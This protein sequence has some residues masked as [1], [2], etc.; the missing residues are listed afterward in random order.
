MLEFDFSKLK[1]DH[2]Y[3]TGITN[4]YVHVTRDI[5][6]RKYWPES[7]SSGTFLGKTT[8]RVPISY[9]VFQ[10]FCE[11]YRSNKFANTIHG[12]IHY[13]NDEVISI[14]IKPRMSLF[15]ESEEWESPFESALGKLKEK[16]ADLKAFDSTIYFD[17]RYLFWDN[18]HTQ[19]LN[20]GVDSAIT[21]KFVNCINMSSLG[22]MSFKRNFNTN[23]NLINTTINEK[24]GVVIRYQPQSN[25][26][27]LTLYS[28]VL[29]IVD[30]SNKKKKR[31]SDDT[32]KAINNSAHFLANLQFAYKTGR[33]IGKLYGNSAIEFL[34]IPKILIENKI[35]SLWYLS[36]ASR[37]L[38]TTH[39]QADCALAWL[40]R[41]LH[42]EK[43]LSHIRELGKCFKHTL[44]Q[45]MIRSTELE[46]LIRKGTSLSDIKVAVCQ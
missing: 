18:K 7:A 3:I 14:N 33:T 28:P 35:P 15:D 37:K 38:Q 10:S 43:R 6:G 9:H 4:S 30:S 21:G 39:I 16:L 19:S 23:Y 27:S 22:V 13:Y 34:Q 11:N 46:E 40:F 42:Q 1:T 45:G 26:K 20:T 29:E 41:F 32:V 25:G 31:T 12:A 5:S 36:S 8:T 17:G 44:E 2:V 24:I